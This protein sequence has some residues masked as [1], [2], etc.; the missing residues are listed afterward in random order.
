MWLH[1][2]YASFAFAIACVLLI[3]GRAV[4]ARYRCAATIRTTGGVIP[5][6][7]FC[8]KVA[9]AINEAG[10]LKD[11]DAVGDNYH[12]RS[13]LA[14][15]MNEDGPI[16]MTVYSMGPNPG[17][18]GSWAT[19]QGNSTDG[20]LQPGVVYIR[21]DFDEFLTPAEAHVPDCVG[22][23]D[24][25]ALVIHELTHAYFRARGGWLVRSPTDEEQLRAIGYENMINRSKDTC[26]RKSTGYQD[27]YDQI[28]Q[29]A[30]GF[31]FIRTAKDCACSQSGFN[32][33]T[34]GCGSLSSY[35]CCKTS[36]VHLDNDSKNCGSCGHPCG[37][38]NPTCCFGQCA[39]L[40]TSQHCA[41][42][43]GACSSASFC[44]VHD[45][46]PTNNTCVSNGLQ[47]P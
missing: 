47:C 20:T 39:S 1:S 13:M 8:A 34:N 21:H 32:G 23:M 4:L 22:N 7:E 43:G 31:D 18:D 44:C 27:I 37:P 11:C 5:D 29:W 35:A 30:G 19:G 41:Q 3:P 25:T 14:E 36:C 15:I 12:V 24:P 38:G 33:P 6:R 46:I 45:S 9:I 2:R 28:V 17:D 16:S 10:E 42:C 40:G 26:Q